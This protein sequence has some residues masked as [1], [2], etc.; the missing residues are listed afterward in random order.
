MNN[1]QT[2]TA[3][4][5]ALSLLIIF[6]INKFRYKISN[7]T[8]LFDYPDNI[9]KFHSKKTP[10][11]GGIII[12]LIF[13]ILNINIFF[14]DTL[15]NNQII[16]LICSSCCFFIGLADD[17]INI[18]YKKKFLYLIIVFIIF[19]NL[20][21]DFQIKEIYFLT[22]KKKIALGI[23]SVP[24][25]ILCL[26]LLI[27]ALNLIDGID[28]LCIM[29]IIIF[30]ICI[31]ISFKNFTINSYILIMSLVIIF[32]LNMK[33]NIFLG[34]SGTLFLGCWIGMDLIHNYNFFLKNKINFPSEIIFI[35]TMIPGID[36]LR[37]F[38]VR[39]INKKNPF[40]AD[41]NHLHHI[42]LRCGFNIYQILVIYGL[43]IL[44]PF[45][46]ASYTFISYNIIIFFCI[47]S[48]LLII[49]RLQKLLKNNF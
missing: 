5:L 31:G 12:Y 26:L 34:D 3:V 1:I 20:S 27:N 2:E 30:I 18:S 22:F 23:F 38:L 24:L 46:I 8:K 29:V 21:S 19:I 49:I 28:G 14:Q 6:I 25:T 45:S 43:L 4:L 37:V 9:R 33:K 32:F 47:I 35:I 48:Y 40:K 42:L 11:L 10:L 16:I 13:F 15:T 7:I 36:M 41:R 39:L 44:I 17:K